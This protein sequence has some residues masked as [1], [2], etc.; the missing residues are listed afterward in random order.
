V[1]RVRVLCACLSVALGCA[2][3][4]VT[5][6]PA[7]V[8]A[9]RRYEPRA[10]SRVPEAEVFFRGEEAFVRR[11]SASGQVEEYSLGDVQKSEMVF[12]P[13]KRKFAY[14]RAKATA[15]TAKPGGAPPMRVLVRNIAGDPVNEFAVYRAGRPDELTWLDNHRIGYLA[16]PPAFDATAPRKPGA[17]PSNVYVV[18]DVDTGEILAARA[19]LEFVWGPQHKHLAFISGPAGKQQVVVDG[20]N[21]WPRFGASKIHGTP[22]WSPDGHGLAFTEDTPQGPR[23]VVLVEFDDAQGDLTWNIPKEATAP[24]LKVF[25]AGDSKVVIGEDALRPRFAADWKR[26]Q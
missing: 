11:P 24:G 6:G 4:G 8:A 18:H 5:E 19:G 10:R 3:A 2:A 25:W 13:D 16:P 12:S 7:K 26:L 15:S 20:Q 14:V 1:K 21:V 22:V 23:L 17:A 9:T